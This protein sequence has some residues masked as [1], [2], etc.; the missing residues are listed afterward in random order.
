NVFCAY[1]SAFFTARGAFLY[2]NQPFAHV[3]GPAGTCITGNQPNADDADDTLNV[4]SH[5][6][7]ETITDPVFRGW[8]TG[9]GSEIADKCSGN[10]GSVLDPGDPLGAQYNQQINGHNYYL[11]QEWSNKSHGCLQRGH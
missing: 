1:H 11:Q 9:R 6:H 5:E 10:F 7:I 3:S 2:T 8:F 4:V